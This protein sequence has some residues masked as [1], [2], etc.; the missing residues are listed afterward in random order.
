MQLTIEGMTCA[1]CVRR[2]EQ[3]IAKTPGVAAANVNLATE[4]AD[5][6]FTAA[7][8]IPAVVKAIES[9]G[10]AVPQDTVELAIQ[11]M[12]CASCVA[13]VEKKLKSV[14]GVTEAAVNL[15]TERG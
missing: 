15:A 11:G 7:P 13:R 6:S 2:V 4:R 14:P 3:S 8:D 1:S 10:Y 9:A 12:T 5:V